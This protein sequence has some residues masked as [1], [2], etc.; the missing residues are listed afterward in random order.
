MELFQLLDRRQL[1]CLNFR[2]PLGG[3]FLPRRRATAQLVEINLNLTLFL[4]RE[5]A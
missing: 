3:R 1:P 5:A 2:N 4:S